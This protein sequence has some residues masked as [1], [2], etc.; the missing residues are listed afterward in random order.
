MTQ[1][2]PPNLLALFQAR[3]PIPYIPPIEKPK[4]PT[5]SGVSQYLS[6]FEDP[7]NVDYSKLRK[8]ENKQARKE[9]KR[10]ERL[11]AEEEKI[12]KQLKIYDSQKNPKATGDAYKTLFVAR[13]SYDTSESKIKREFEEYGPIKKIR[14]IHDSKTGKPRGYAFIEFEKEKDMRNAYKLADGKKIDGRRVLVDVERGRTVKGWRP[15]RFGGGLGGTRAGGDD[16]NTKFSGREPPSALT[17][18]GSPKDKD[19]KDELDREKERERDNK[20]LGKERDRDRDRDRER[21]RGEREYR[22]RDRNKERDRDDKDHRD[23][24]RD[25]DRE[26][27]RGDRDKDR[28]RSHRDR[29]DRDKDRERD[30]DRDHRDRDRDREYKDRDKEPR[31]DLPDVDYEKDHSKERR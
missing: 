30:R 2:L 15:R 13:A 3:P 4:L 26:R 19:L 1:H 23:R 7:A 16:V 28:D 21:E 11:T 20:D 12:S 8:V 10:K 17:S 27:D 29:R 6:Q 14:L 25:K 5:Y 18:I 24:D 22:D 9:R 31:D